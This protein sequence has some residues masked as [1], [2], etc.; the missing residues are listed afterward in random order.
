MLTERRKVSQ[1]KNL[2]QGT[3]P[4]FHYVAA[5]GD[6]ARR[7]LPA[8]AIDHFVC[9]GER[10]IPVDLKRVAKPPA[11]VLSREAARP[12]RTCARLAARAQIA[13]KD[14]RVGVSQA[15]QFHVH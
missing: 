3:R 8:M 15:Q 11:E 1:I 7:A 10:D 6:L 9:R 13:Q 12:V 2:P 4:E 14:A 5:V